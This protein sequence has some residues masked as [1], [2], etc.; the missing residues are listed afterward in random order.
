M[1]LLITTFSIYEFKTDNLSKVNC[2]SEK[3]SKSVV[4]WIGLKKF[5]RGERKNNIHYFLHQTNKILSTFK[6]LARFYHLK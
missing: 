4:S 3:V 2:I 1:C 6:N 5:E